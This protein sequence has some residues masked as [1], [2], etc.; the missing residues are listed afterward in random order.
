MKIPIDELIKKTYKLK[1]TVLLGVGPMSENLVE[2]CIE[3]AKE[4]DF[5]LMFIASRNQIDLKKFGGGYV[6]GWD[7]F[8]FA[9]RIKKIAKKYDFQDYYLC[10]DHGGPWQRDEERNAHLPLEEAMEIANQLAKTARA[11]LPKVM[12][13]PTPSIA[14]LA[15]IPE[16]K[17][18]PSMTKNVLIGV[19]IAFLI[20]ISSFTASASMISCSLR[21]DNSSIVISQ[22]FFIVKPPRVNVIIDRQ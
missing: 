4:K 13:A 7:Q 22:S 5:P 20:M 16:H 12:E 14:E 1:D 21:K 2:T 3:L 17:S 11:Q 15:V 9:D 10:R 19:L 6:G 8:D 18:S